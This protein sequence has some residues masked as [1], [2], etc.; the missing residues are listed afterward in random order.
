[1]TWELPYTTSGASASRGR[2]LHCSE[3]YIYCTQRHSARS[4]QFFP[5]LDFVS[6]SE[7]LLWQY[8][9]QIDWFG[10]VCVCS[11]RCMAF[12]GSSCA[13]TTHRVKILDI[14]SIIRSDE[15]TWKIQ[16]ILF[17]RYLRVRAHTHTQT[18]NNKIGT[19]Y[20]IERINTG[21]CIICRA[22]LR[23]TELLLSK[24]I[25]KL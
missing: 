12:E 5:F 18:D 19:G 3:T 10:W 23:P 7:F 21:N 24:R 4:R 17:Q 8:T 1:M 20:Q 6:S 9:I 11:V 25:Q 16:S 13:N 14:V 2:A 22:V 15:S